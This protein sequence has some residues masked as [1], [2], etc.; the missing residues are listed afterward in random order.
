MEMPSPNVTPSP[1]PIPHAPPPS[2]GTTAPIDQQQCKRL[3]FLLS[4]W[5]LVNSHEFDIVEEPEFIELISALQ[6][7]Y[8]LPS[9]KV[10][11]NSLLD[12]LYDHYENRVKNVCCP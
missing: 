9:R 1:Q 6:P 2:T 5:I 11:G 8:K 3:D 10:I 12:E 7:Q 4:K